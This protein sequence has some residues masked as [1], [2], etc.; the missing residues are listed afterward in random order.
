VGTRDKLEV[1]GVASEGGEDLTG[2][3]VLQVPVV[4]DIGGVDIPAQ[5]YVCTY[6]GIFPFAPE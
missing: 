1:S 4:A 3:P 5:G 2:R 6:A